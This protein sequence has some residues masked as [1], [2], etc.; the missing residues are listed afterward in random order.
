M[1][2]GMRFVISTC[3]L[4]LYYSAFSQPDPIETDRPDQTET[5]SLVPLKHFQVEM[6]FNIE[7]NEQELSYVHPTILWKMGVFRAAEV[8]L[9]TDIVSAKDSNG[10]YRVG[11]APVQIGFKAAIC[12]EKKGRPK[13]S[14]IGHLAIPPISTK[15]Q[16]TK[17][18]AP[19]FRFTLEHTL[20][21]NISLGYNIGME[22]DGFSPQPAFIYTI[23][24]GYNLSQ[25]W[26]LYYEFF[27]D[28]PIGE[29]STHFFDLGLA[30]LI[31]NN[32][33]A[34]LSGGMQVYPFAKG[35]YTALGFSFRL[36]D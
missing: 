14:F 19:N 4:I 21:E 35:W 20:K 27:G 9:I 17:Y 8:R 10:V 33:Q 23:V 36:P 15:S 2:A 32:L 13:I 25:S 26:Y 30:W 12:E 24:N 7:S 6:G 28:I 11:L 31:K 16:R 29:R 18:V 1:F 3:L 34:D 5:P 22:W